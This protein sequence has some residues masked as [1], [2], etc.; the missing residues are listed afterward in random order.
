MPF[1]EP[2]AGELPTVH[3]V[4]TNDDLFVQMRK[5]T[6]A[7]TV[8]NRRI[9]LGKEIN[10][11]EH[12]EAPSTLNTGLGLV[13]L[14]GWYNEHNRDKV[15]SSSASNQPD[16]PVPSIVRALEIHKYV[17]RL[18]IAQGAM[19]DAVTV[20]NLT[21]QLVRAGDSVL[22]ETASATGKTLGAVGTGLNSFENFD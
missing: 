12:V 11:I 21:K 19:Q 4:E 22:L 1:V 7:E 18:Q 9:G 8:H 5:Y 17:S 20:M 14:T 16:S 2:K 6:D 15:S 10:L 3:W 13:A